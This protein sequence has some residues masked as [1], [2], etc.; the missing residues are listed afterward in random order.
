MN[1]VNPLLIFIFLIFS[2]YVKSQQDAQYTNYM[3]N[4]QLIQ[5]AYVGTSG[6]TKMTFLGRIQ[7]IDLNGG[8]ETLTY[9]L[10]LL[11][12]KTKIWAWGYL[13]FQ[14][15]YIYIY[16]IENRITIDYGYSINFPF[17]K[18]TFGLKGG[19]SELD[20]DYSQLNIAD[21][22]DPYVLYNS[23]KLKPEVGLGIYFNT[24]NYYLG[25]S[26]PN[27]LETKYYDEF[28]IENS[29][30]SKVANRIHYYGMAG[31]VFDLTKNIKVKPA[32]LIKVVEGSPIQWDL[33]IN[34]LFNRKTTI[35][36]ANRLDSAFCLLG[37]FQLSQKF[38]LGLSYDYMTNEIRSV[39]SGSYEIVFRF[40][41]F[42][43][44]G[45]ILT[46]RFF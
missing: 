30:F 31:F 5:P 45:K 27:I 6:Y 34:F 15:K 41:L 29:S 42:S 21:E 17:S 3:Y 39:N 44:D 9:L 35:G 22:N 36:I 11:S 32:S 8:P 25:I 10:I 7:W 23:N 1:K 4:T 14:I 43:N 16:Y 12:E 20:V 38:F 26:A 37:G 46:P 18:L 40:N 2:S 19:I 33:S 28:E 24:E 13:F